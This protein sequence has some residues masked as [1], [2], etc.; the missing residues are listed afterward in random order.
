MAE[1]N[2]RLNGR[3]IR[4]SMGK[5]LGG[6]S[7]INVSTWSRGHR[8]DW[9]FYAAE[10][11]DAAWGYDAVL[12]LYRR[13]IEAW[14][15]HPDPEYPRHGRNGPCAAGRRPAPLRARTPRRRQI[16]GAGAFPESEWSHDGSAGR[17]RAGRRDRARWAP[18]VDL[19]VLCLSADGPA[20][21]DGAQ[22]RPGDAGSV[23]RPSRDGHRGPLARQEG[24]RGRRARGR[25]VA[26][27]DPHTETPDA[28]RHRRRGRVEA[29]GHRRPAS[30]AGRGA[31][32]ARSCGV[33]MRLGKHLPRA[34]RRY[35]EARQRAS[36]R[37]TPGW[38]PRTST[39]TRGE[40]RRSR[41][42]MLAASTHRRPAGRW[43]SA[44][45]RGVGALCV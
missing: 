29:P 24:S 12:D 1:P 16:A 38:T 6:G 27:C 45:A 43:W 13:R 7:S 40:D 36:G 8:A 11:G 4:Y 44:C 42:R 3:A 32:P 30:F 35:R 5:V 18:A 17:L 33:R 19:P 31:Q 22:G 10:A 9:D 23:R 26:R 39:L 28:I 37:H 14:T 20:E 25:A 15:G 41:R 21:P 2:A 34:R